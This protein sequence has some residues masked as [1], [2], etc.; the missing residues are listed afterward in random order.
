MKKIYIAT[1]YN[2]WTN[3]ELHRAFKTEQEADE[4]LNGLTD[5]H[6]VVMSYQSTTQLANALLGNQG[7]TA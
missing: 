2:S 3:K 1:G 7:V 4:F 5:P 6:L